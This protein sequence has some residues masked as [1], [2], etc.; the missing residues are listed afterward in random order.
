MNLTVL[1]ISAFSAS[2]ILVRPSAG[3][4][5]GGSPVSM[6]KLPWRF[7]A[8]ISLTRLALGCSWAVLHPYVTEQVASFGVPPESLGFWVGVIEASLQLAEGLITPAIVYLSEF[9]GRK[10][11]IL[12]CMMLY[13]W[14][15]LPIG[16]SQSLG[17]LFFWRM[18]QGMFTAFSPITKGIVAE[19]CD[20]SNRSQSVYMP[21]L[22]HCA[23]ALTYTM[24][25][26]LR[27]DGIHVWNR[28]HV[29]SKPIGSSNFIPLIYALSHFNFVSPAVDRRPSG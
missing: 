8:P 27:T 15:L 4:N 21:G 29:R 2:A 13:S 9:T 25:C 14:C 28:I 16:I 23:M 17:A 18:A 11:V 26:R 6:G 12:A 19:V 7:I 22:L 10:P 24:R 5:P 1:G 20:D 3:S